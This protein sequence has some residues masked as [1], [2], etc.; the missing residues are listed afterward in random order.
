MIAHVRQCFLGQHRRKL[1]Q[2]PGVWSAGGRHMMAV[3]ML[4][5]SECR[6]AAKQN[7]SNDGYKNTHISS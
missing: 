7:S 4:G 3:L 2:L 6:A 5:N 1:Y